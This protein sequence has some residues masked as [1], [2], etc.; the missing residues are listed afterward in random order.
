M[1]GEI[2]PE[3][4]ARRIESDDPPL[5]VDVR[6]PGPFSR[7]HIPGSENVPFA[8]LPNRVDDLADADADHVVTV[9]PHGQSSVQAARLIASYEGT[10]DARIESMAGGLEA[11]PGDL[12]A[13]GPA[14]Q[15]ER[16]DPGIGDGSDATDDGDA[17]D[18]PF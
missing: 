6:A 8:D 9:C 10:A 11:W 18:A 15:G 14:G 7:G 5:I 2:T 12:V 16:A 13:S 4:V 1:D 3:E 17:A